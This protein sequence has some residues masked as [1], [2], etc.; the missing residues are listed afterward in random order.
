MPA[1]R[2]HRDEDALGVADYG[3]EF[4]SVVERGNVCGAQFHPEKSSRNGL[5]LLRNFAAICARVAA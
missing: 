3:G 1:A 4:V 5:A 2:V